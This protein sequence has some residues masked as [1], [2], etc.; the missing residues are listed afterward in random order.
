MCLL[1]FLNSNPRTSVIP[2][3]NVYM[4][5]L[6]QPYLSHQGHK[7]CECPTGHPS[8]LPWDLHLMDSKV[9][10]RQW[11]YRQPHNWPEQSRGDRLIHQSLPFL[12]WLLHTDAEHKNFYFA[13][14]LYGVSIVM[15]WADGWRTGLS[16]WFCH[17]EPCQMW[18]PSSTAKITTLHLDSS[19]LWIVLIW[20][21]WVESTSKPTIVYSCFLRRLQAQGKW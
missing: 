9:R 2:Y 20:D 1:R 11:R 13:L 15:S 7:E 19:L 3:P 18:M 8:P 14:F 21:I 4:L 16:G 12:K 5:R 6:Q 17:A 10:G